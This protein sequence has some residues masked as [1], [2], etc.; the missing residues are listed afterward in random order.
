MFVGAICLAIGVVMAGVRGSAYVRY[1]DERVASL[2][3]RVSDAVDATESEHHFR[4]DAPAD[5]DEGD[6]DDAGV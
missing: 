2:A 6:D 4:S 3:A 5:Y 1:C